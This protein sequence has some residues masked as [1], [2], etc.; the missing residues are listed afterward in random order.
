M[1]YS[2]CKL[3]MWNL[4]GL[5]RVSDILYKCG[6]DMAAK[7]DLHHWDNSHI[8]NWIILGLCALKNDIY[9]VCDDR[10]AVA[11]FQT[12]KIGDSYLF[13]KLATLPECAGKGIG[14]FCL[15]E[16]ERLGKQDNCKEIICEVY[17]LSEHAKRFYENRGYVVYGETDTLKYRELKLKKEL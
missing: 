3:K 12:R 10:T 6:K 1:L 16:I 5:L 15:G 4:F 9:L 17:D 8:K 14:A 11:T 7:Y 2:V 13:Q